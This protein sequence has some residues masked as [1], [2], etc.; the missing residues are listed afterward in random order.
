VRRDRKPKGSGLLTSFL[1]AFFR[2]RAL[3]RLEASERLDRVVSRTNGSQTRRAFLSALVGGGATLGA[4][5]SGCRTRARTR[6]AAT[7]AK[8]CLAVVPAH[9]SRVLLKPDVPGEGPLPDGFFKYPAQLVRVIEHRPGRSAEPITTMNAWWG[10]TPAGRGRNAYVDAIDA[11]LGVP[12]TPSV[13]DGNHYAAKLSAMLAARDIPD[14]L[15]VP[16]WEVAKI[17]RYSQAVAALFADLTE[18]LRGDAVKAYPMLATLPTSAWTYSVWGGR[19]SAVPFPQNGPPFPWAMFYRKDVCD[20]AGVGAPASIDEL[21]RF[22][23]KM[24]EPNRNVWAFGSVFDMVQMYFKCSGVHG[25]WRK[26]AS[27]GLEHKYETLE[28]RQALEF[29]ARLHREGLVHPDIIATNGSDQKQLFRSGRLLC[30]QEGLGTWRPMQSEESRITPG[31]DMQPIYLF[32]AVGGRPLAWAADE[33]IFY[34]FIKKKLSRE[35]IEEMLRV[36]DWCAAPFGSVEH[37]LNE[38][39]VEGQHFVRAPDGSPL[40]TELGRKELALQFQ[41]LG[42]RVPSLVGTSDVP[43]FVNDLLAYARNALSYR[44]PN[45]FS[46]I[47][48]ELPPNVSRVSVPTESKIND[49]IR[50]RR[51]LGDLGQIVHEWRRS[52][53]DEGREFLEQVLADNAA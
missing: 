52:G 31:F 53:G 47:K 48:I 38:F 8:D 12:V 11:E 20:R 50:G 33:P 43:H 6:G 14:I 18:Y 25:G 30:C 4:L 42:G 16:S 17:P 7:S 28:Y 19:L 45:P 41:V 23:K 2:F 29:T 15:S 22:G 44:E 1:R 40:P 34:T 5:G 27:G 24:T 37:C 46:G 36:L 26:S 39:G 9:M 13:Q 32:S 3:K 35:R 49:I 10:P 51:P 21:Y